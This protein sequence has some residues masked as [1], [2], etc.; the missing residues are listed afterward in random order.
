MPSR[1]WVYILLIALALAPLVACGSPEGRNPS[2]DP[3]ET[4]TQT[5]SH[6]KQEDLAR[7]MPKDG[8]A[9]A[10]LVNGPLLGIPQF[11]G[12]TLAEY[13]KAGRSFQQILFKAP[14]VAMTAV[15]L[16]HGKDAMTK[17]KFV[18]SFGGYYGEIDG[19]PTFLFVKNEYVAALIGLPLQDADAEGR[20]AAASIP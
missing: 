4:A 19:K 3:A 18:A 10:S 11:P 12:G 1:I 20:V 7:F 5:I 16:S 2:K 6:A 17:P 9:S 15:Y 14:N 8:R 13:K